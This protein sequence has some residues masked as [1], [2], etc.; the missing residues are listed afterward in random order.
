VLW[1]EDRPVRHAFWNPHGRSR[2]AL[3]SAALLLATTEASTHWKAEPT[4][5]AYLTVLRHCLD[6]LPVRDGSRC[7]S[8]SCL[9]GDEDNGQSCFAFFRH[10]TRHERRI[11]NAPDHLCPAGHLGRTQRRPVVSRY[12]LVAR[13]KRTWLGSAAVAPGDTWPI[14]ID[15]GALRPCRA[16][17]PRVP[18]PAGLDSPACF[19]RSDGDH[20]LARL[21][22]AGNAHAGHA[23]GCGWR[24]RRA[25]SAESSPHRRG[26]APRRP[27][28]PGRW[29][30]RT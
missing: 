1:W 22:P 14:A 8:A 2:A 6:T 24:G 17:G 20:G 18:A 12:A 4:A 26:P 5:L 21:L 25:G 15:R 23:C 29:R 9:R 27:S 11:P 7:S 3:G 19:V 10:G 16:D 28:R 13:T 30:T